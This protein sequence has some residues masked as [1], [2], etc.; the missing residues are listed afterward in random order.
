MPPAHATPG[1]EA[2]NEEV[3]WADTVRRVAD[4][5]RHWPRPGWARGLSRR[6]A[7]TGDDG[8]SSWGLSNNEVLSVFDIW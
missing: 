4:L 8:G 2:V 7:S 5:T 1:F 6:Q 3:S